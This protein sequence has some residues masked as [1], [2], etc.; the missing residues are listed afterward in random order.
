MGVTVSKPTRVLIDNMAV[1]L[2]SN[3]PGST[4]NKKMVA[5]A[6]HF[7]REHVANDVVEVKKD[8]HKRQLR[9]P[10]YQESGEQ[11]IP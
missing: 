3:N 11:R 9:R 5:L 10:I 8:R 2:N 4:L 6:Y 7:V 1:I